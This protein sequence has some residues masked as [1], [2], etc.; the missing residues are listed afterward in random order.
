MCGIVGI[1]HQ[2]KP[3]DPR[4]I[5]RA[6]ESIHSR[7]PD[8]QGIWINKNMA[9]GHS[10]L[11][12]IDPKEGHQ[13]MFSEDGQFGIVYNGE[14]YNYRELRKTLRARGHRFLT[15]SDTEV[16]LHAYM[17]WKDECV[18]HLRGMFAFAVIDRTRQLFFLARDHLGIKPLVY[19]HTPDCFVFAS[20][21]QAIKAFGN[22]VE[23]NIDP[24][25]IDAYL[26]T[27][28]IPA[29]NTIYLQVKK[30]RP[31]Y[32][33]KVSFDGKLLDEEQY[34]DLEV[35]VDHS[36]SEAEW[37]EELDT[38]LRESVKAHMISDVPYGAFLSGGIDSSLVVSYMS[39]LLDTPVET[40]SI[41]F[42]E[43]EF[44]ELKYAR[45]VA[46]R[47][48][49]KHH[50]HIITP[51]ALN[52]LPDLVRHYG[53]PFG[54]S[55]AIPTYYVSKLARENVPMVLSGDGAD[56][57]FA[58]YRSYQRWMSYLETGDTY[59]AWKK[60][61]R[62]FLEKLFPEKY[63]HRFP[64]GDRLENWL[65][66]VQ[67][68][69]ER[70]RQRLWRPEYRK[71][72]TNKIDAF[73]SAY[74]TARGFSALKKAQ[75]LD[76][77]TYLPNDILTK[78]DIVSMMHGLEVR[79]PFTDKRVYEVAASIPNEINFS[80]IGSH[81]LQGKKLL[82]KLLVPKTSEAF[83]YRKKMGFALPVKSWFSKEGA[84]RKELN[85]R[86]LSDDSML[87][88]YFERKVIAKILQSGRFGNIWLL[89]F[90]DEWLRQEK[91]R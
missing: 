33:M 62:P 31:G 39:E 87:N 76:I 75:Y 53:E 34:W 85:D 10:R 35:K 57:I 70:S 77:K 63:S 83:V 28:Y 84:Y 21:L 6:T 80:D 78:V 56:E 19:Y 46:Q 58:G 90:L 65:S 2:K 79:T 47:F 7:G 12:I 69:P 88:D 18:K 9:L 49:T 16:L 44:N 26:R 82:K 41:G 74:E 64:F 1:I 11:S 48:H 40:F 55:S 86:L 71:I 36:K 51:D 14:I 60:G 8:E 42:H 61:I 38:I 73:E 37:L 4:S 5:E 20:E 66:F 91:V 59:P 32:R 72:M 22:E 43:E 13:P 23:L 15:D 29:P 54:D 68:I 17:E 27:Q 50:E 3:V 30:L 25:A 81:G 67:Y 45:E 89:L 52:I 24:E